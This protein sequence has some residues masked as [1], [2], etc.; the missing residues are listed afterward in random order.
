ML[1][2]S[3]P[4]INNML[5]LSEATEISRPKLYEYL[6]HLQEARLINLVRPKGQGYA[7]LRRP[8]KI[9]LENTNLVHAITEELNTG[10]VRE[11]FFVNQ[12]KNAFSSQA[13]FLDSAIEVSKEGDFTVAGKYTF[14]VGGKGKS[15]KQ[16]KDL[17]DSYIAADDIEIG[18]GNKIPL[19]LFGFLY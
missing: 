14:E 15:Y 18:H 17:S 13:A 2:S 7:L 9:Y 10:T 1:A 11:L 12:L 5:K 16:I 6:S 4:F 3:L 8:E 19:W